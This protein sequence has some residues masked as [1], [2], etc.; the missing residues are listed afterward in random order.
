[1]A[2]RVKSQMERV[3]WGA[4]PLCTGPGCTFSSGGCSI[5]CSENKKGAR[6]GPGRPSATATASVRG[7]LCRLDRDHGLVLALVV[8]Q[9]DQRHLVAG[10][11][12]GQGRDRLALDRDRLVVGVALDGEGL[13]RGVHRDDL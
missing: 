10:L 3:L 13:G 7:G 1:M 6:G 8:I 5:P 4:L 2:T 11:V 9:A 12:A